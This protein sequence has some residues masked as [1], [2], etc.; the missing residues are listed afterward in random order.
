MGGGAC[1][2]GPP[3]RPEGQA[4]ARAC[5][6][7]ETV[8]PSIVGG[9]RLGELTGPGGTGGIAPRLGRFGPPGTARQGAGA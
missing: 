5:W 3:R 9:V 2:V 7:S 6:N 4:G 8:M 1:S